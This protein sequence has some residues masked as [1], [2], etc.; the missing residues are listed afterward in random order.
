ML[1]FPALV[2]CLFYN[3]VWVLIIRYTT[4]LWLI[5]GW[6]CPTVWDGYPIDLFWTIFCNLLHIWLHSIIEFSTILI[7][8]CREQQLFQKHCYDFWLFSLNIDCKEHMCIHVELYTIF[9]ICHRYSILRAYRYRYIILSSLKLDSLVDF[10]TSGTLSG[11]Y[12]LIYSFT[13]SC[14][15]LSSTGVSSMIYSGWGF[16]YKSYNLTLTDCWMVWS[17]CMVWISSWNFMNFSFE[18]SSYFNVQPHWIY[19]LTVWILPWAT[20]VS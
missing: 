4:Q 2:V 1:C 12:V 20:F 14:T 17:C 16:Y 18:F 5:I 19:F 7:E 8:F 3:H 6:F 13:V 11:T 10:C 15:V 9:Q